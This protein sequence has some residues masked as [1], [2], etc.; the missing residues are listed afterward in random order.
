LVIA[1]TSLN[2]INCISQENYK[3][4]NVAIGGGGYVTDIVVH[5]K[6]RD[7]IYF[8]TDVGGLFKWD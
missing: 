6:E 7:L 3:W 1:L 5:P 2:I 4:D 8:Q